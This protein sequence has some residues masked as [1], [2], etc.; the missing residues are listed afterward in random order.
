MVVSYLNQENTW[1]LREWYKIETIE[2]ETA[3]TVKTRKRKQ[4]HYRTMK[5]K[6]H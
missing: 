5:R 4:K 3:P 2:E 6:L 1:G